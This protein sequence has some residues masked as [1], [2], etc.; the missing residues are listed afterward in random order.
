MRYIG[1]GH[2]C[3]ANVTAMLLDAVGECVKPEIV[4]VLS[5]VG[6]GA[7][8]LKTDDLIFFDSASPDRGIT[9]ALRLLGFAVQEQVSMDDDPPPW[10]ALKDAL[11]RGPA[12]LSP[13]DLGLLTHMSGRLK[14]EQ[15]A[16]FGRSHTLLV[17][18]DWPAAADTF[19]RLATVEDLF[20]AGVAAA[21]Q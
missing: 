10:P 19:D 9:T 18:K 16:L 13:V 4:E 12:I 17:R 3:Y 20:R 2:Y 5:G 15:A 14:E 8:W 11:R 6:V 21:A 7:H 1:N